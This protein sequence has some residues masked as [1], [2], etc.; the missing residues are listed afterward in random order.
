MTAPQGVCDA[1]CGVCFLDVAGICGL[2]RAALRAWRAWCSHILGGEIWQGL[3]GGTMTSIVPYRCF[4][5]FAAYGKVSPRCDEGIA[6]YRLFYRLSG[7]FFVYSLAGLRRGEVTPPSRLF[8]CL[9]YSIKRPGG[10]GLDRSGTWREM[11]LQ[12]SITP[13]SRL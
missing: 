9:P 12:F 1:P 13:P 4:A 5:M 11:T 8:Y 6:F 2:D 10:N 3:A 7:N